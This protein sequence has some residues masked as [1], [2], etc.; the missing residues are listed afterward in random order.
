MKM[1]LLEIYYKEKRVAYIDEKGDF[2]C[3]D[4]KKMIESLMR[5]TKNLKILDK[6]SNKILKILKEINN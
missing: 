3:S 2:Y 5:F 1:Y 4:K 6:N